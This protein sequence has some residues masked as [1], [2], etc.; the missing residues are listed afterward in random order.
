MGGRSAPLEPIFPWGLA[1]RKLAL[2]FLLRQPPDIPL[3][4]GGFLMP[5]AKPKSPSRASGKRVAQEHALTRS[6]PASA[7]RSARVSAVTTL[8]IDIG[9][10]GIKMIALDP[11]G[12]PVTERARML[13][14]HPA[15]PVAV[16]D[17]I[18]R[19][20]A[21]QP[22]F[23]RVSVGFPGVVVAGVV[24]TAANLGTELWKGHDLRRDIERLAGAPVQVINDADLQGYGVIEGRGV[25]LV[26][27]LGTGL[28]SALYVDGRL[29][30]NLELGHHPFKKG[31]TYEERVSDAALKRIGKK[32]WTRRVLEALDQLTLTFNPRFIFLG[33]GNVEHLRGELPKHV[34]TFTNV[35]GMTGG[36]KLW[37]SE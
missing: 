6:R 26:L 13:T 15:R 37:A 3:E 22:R 34:R 4:M 2:S 30:P 25:E 24:R 33:G 8:C 20:L 7:P 1:H 14:P 23:D 5:L 10:T 31:K 35:D 36:I 9:G 29:V 12:R 16:L 32:D 21:S 19:M 28:G 17:V 18:R 11:R 27:T